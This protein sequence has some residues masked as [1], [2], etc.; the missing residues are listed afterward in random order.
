MVCSFAMYVCLYALQTRARI[1]VFGVHMYHLFIFWYV[2][3]SHIICSLI[4]GV[5]IHVTMLVDV[6]QLCALFEL[7]IHCV[8][9]PN[10]GQYESLLWTQ[11]HTSTIICENSAVTDAAS[12]SIVNNK[13]VLL[14]NKSAAVCCIMASLSFLLQAIVEEETSGQ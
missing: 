1:S 4:C 3:C 13:L 12:V 6:Q 7:G 8:D 11:P 2:H 5:F 10:Q 9:L 14:D